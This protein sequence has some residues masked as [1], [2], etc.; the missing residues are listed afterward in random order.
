MRLQSVSFT[1]AGAVTVSQIIENVKTCS[2]GRICLFTLD[3]WRAPP[4]R[5]AVC[6]VWFM[7]QIGSCMPQSAVLWWGLLPS[8]MLVVECLWLLALVSLSLSLSWRFDW[9][10]TVWMFFFSSAAAKQVQKLSVMLNQMLLKLI[11][12]WLLLAKPQLKIKLVVGYCSRTL[13]T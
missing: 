11:L 2:E 7:I 12:L 1:L 10:V 13:S 9:F 6:F 3:S 8:V 4:R 5:V